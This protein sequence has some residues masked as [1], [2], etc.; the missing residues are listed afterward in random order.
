MI[1]PNA[2]IDT[3][4]RPA[5]PGIT[6]DS[7]HRSSGL[8]IASFG[9][10]STAGISHLTGKAVSFGGTGGSEVLTWTSLLPDDDWGIRAPLTPMTPSAFITTLNAGA[11]VRF[12]IHGYDQF[13]MPQVETTPWVALT[14]GAANNQ[15]WINFSRVFAYVERVFYQSVVVNNNFSTIA[16]GWHV[17]FD[18]SILAAADLGAGLGNTNIQSYGTNENWGLGTPLRIGRYPDNAGVI[19]VEV[20]QAL[21]LNIGD[22]FA[23]T[24]IP[25][26]DTTRTNSA[27]YTLGRSLSGWQGT[28]NKVGLHSDDWANEKIGIDGG[29]SSTNPDNIP[30][31]LGDVGEDYIGLFFTI[32]T[33]L[34]TQRDHQGTSVYVWG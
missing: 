2:Q 8:R 33:R 24:V 10:S 9:L 29:G 15:H 18:P 27:G 14:A 7:V 23:R 22:N 34:G 13:W 32:R 28:P 21:G 12:R 20:M 5:L 11:K 1:D 30:D 19:N 4:I 6:E 31:A 16:I 25:P 3:I 17:S 26:Y